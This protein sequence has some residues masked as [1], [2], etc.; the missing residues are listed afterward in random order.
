MNECMIECMNESQVKRRGSTCQAPGSGLG[1]SGEQS[2][3]HS[4]HVPGAL[5]TSPE[6]G[7]APGTSGVVALHLRH[8]PCSQGVRGW[9]GATGGNH[10]LW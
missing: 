1:F 4:A 7:G 5:V 2:C 6:V 3:L 10:P 9:A 8:R